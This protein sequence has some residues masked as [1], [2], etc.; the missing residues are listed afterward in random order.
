MKPTLNRFSV[1]STI[2]SLVQ[3]YLNRVDYYYFTDN[4]V[5]RIWADQTP[6]RSPGAPSPRPWSP[7]NRRRLPPNS[8]AIPTKTSGAP[9]MSSSAYGPGYFQRSSAHHRRKDKVNVYSFIILRWHLTEY[10]LFS[11]YRKGFDLLSRLG[12]DSRSR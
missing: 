10:F 1:M 4:H 11:G 2:L 3:F 8:V 12:C 9:I 6:L 7:E 5:Q